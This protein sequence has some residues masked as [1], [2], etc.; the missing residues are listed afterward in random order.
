MQEGGICKA[1][2]EAACLPVSGYSGMR[3][4][5]G[6]EGALLPAM[7]GG[8]QHVSVRGVA[9]T[10]ACRETSVFLR[11]PCWRSWGGHT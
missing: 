7:G 10:A 11:T 8:D 3:V 1:G 5:S 2:H 9:H 4:G 6:E